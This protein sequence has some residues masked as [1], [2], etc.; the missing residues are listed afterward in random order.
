[1]RLIYFYTHEKNKENPSVVFLLN[2]L[3]WKSPRPHRPGL[4]PTPPNNPPHRPSHCF[5]P[6][7]VSSRLPWHQQ[8]HA[9][10]RAWQRQILQCHDQRRLLRPLVGLRLRPIGRPCRRLR[11]LADEAAAAA[12]LALFVIA[13][14]EFLLREAVPE[15][16]CV[17]FWNNN[18]GHPWRT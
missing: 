11:H 1:M 9:D 5:H 16:R 18:F 4:E 13:V 15:E 8:I 14:G 12:A 2:L 7:P 10:E 17:Q 3:R 6:F